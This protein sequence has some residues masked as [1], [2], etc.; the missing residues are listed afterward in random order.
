MPDHWLHYL[1]HRL[2]KPTWITPTEVARK[3]GIHPQR[4]RRLAEWYALKH[5][6]TLRDYM[7]KTGP[8]THIYLLPP[9]FLEF[10]KQELG[11]S[12]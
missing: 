3:L 11:I 2:G 8:V 12:I 10:V 1:K 9:D 4:A 6:K 7:V 5:G